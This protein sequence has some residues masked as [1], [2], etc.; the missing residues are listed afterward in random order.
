MDERLE[1]AS[2]AVGM[3]IA[4]AD[5]QELSEMLARLAETGHAAP[6]PG[7]GRAVRRDLE[8]MRR[9]LDSSRNHLDRI[10]HA[11]VGNRRK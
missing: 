7:A 10:E 2:F 11:A 3:Q 8:R 9:L 1:A 6:T 5:L 4:Y